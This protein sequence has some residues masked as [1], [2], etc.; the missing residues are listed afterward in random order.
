ML[1]FCILMLVLS[2]LTKIP[3]GE[4]IAEP[5]EYEVKGAHETWTFKS[6]DDCFEFRELRKSGWKGNAEDFYKW[7]EEE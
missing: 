5:E 1:E 4:P 7:K 3:V 6:V 2:L